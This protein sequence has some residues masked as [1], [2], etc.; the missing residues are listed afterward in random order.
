MRNIRCKTVSVA[1]GAHL[2]SCRPC[3]TL[4]L[5]FHGYDLKH[6]CALLFYFI[7]YIFFS[8]Y[9][10]TNILF[11]C[12]FFFLL[13]RLST[14]ENKS[15]RLMGCYCCNSS[16]INRKFT[17]KKYFTVWDALI[18]QLKTLNDA[19]VNK[20]RTQSDAVVGLVLNSKL[21]CTCIFF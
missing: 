3:P 9:L 2:R 13:T 4:F 11:F 10:P 21:H 17:D 7:L 6:M 5:W 8:Y 19:V 18:D 1:A 12:F 15:L 14:L 16:T 20:L